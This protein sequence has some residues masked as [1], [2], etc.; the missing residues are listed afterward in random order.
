MDRHPGTYALVI[1]VPSSCRL[2]VGA[3]GEVPLHRGY[4]VYVGS[5]HGPGGLGA[6]INRH[7]GR[8]KRIHWHV[9]RLTTRFDVVE[10]WTLADARRLEHAWSDAVG[11]MEG[12]EVSVPRFG[13]SDCGCPTHLWHFARRPRASVMP[14]KVRIVRYR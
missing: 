7:L 10:V 6:R 11:A 3:L 2:A 12:A 5:A 1:H 8:D 4:H 14:W 9:D 13:S